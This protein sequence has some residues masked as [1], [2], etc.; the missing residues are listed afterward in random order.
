MADHKPQLEDGYTRIA[1]EWLEA[2][3]QYPAPGSLKNFAEYR[4]SPALTLCGW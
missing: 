3:I 1:N 4:D 2:F